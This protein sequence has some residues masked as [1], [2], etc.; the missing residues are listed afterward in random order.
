MIYLLISISC[1]VTVAVLLKLAKRYKINIQQAVAW[2]YL[3]AIGLSW[4]F[5]KPNLSDL[6]GTLPSP[7]YLALGVL[8]PV[9]F[10]F[11]AASVKS[12]G[13]AKT[14]I[15]QRLS[16]FIP[17]LASYFLFNESFTNLRLCGLAVGFFAIFLTL[18]RKTGQHNLTNNWLYPIVVF[19]GFGVIDTL[20]K[21]VAQIK[22]IPYTSSLI[23]IF[24]LSFIVSI[25]SIL[26]L[27]FVKKHK[28]QLVNFVCGCIL[29]FFNFFNILFYLKAHA[30]M[31]DNPSVVFAAM[32]MGVIVVGS[33]VG[34]LIFKEK[35]HKLNYIGL[36]LALVAIAII[37]ISKIYAI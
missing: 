8:L 27:H 37:T 26:Y 3:F 15:A 4:F 13:I 35:L 34:I 22:D 24:G 25:I 9:V 31:A 12:I 5:F 1:S 18:Y 20:F 7:V 17:L 29:G 30:A 23:L 19:I 10:W 36:C 6:T 2:N 14:D 33:L 16:L 32:N 21:K 11:L 28:I